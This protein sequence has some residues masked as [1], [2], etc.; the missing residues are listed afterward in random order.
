MCFSVRSLILISLVI[1]IRQRV[2]QTSEV[3]GDDLILIFVSLCYLPS[4]IEHGL[5]LVELLNARSTIREL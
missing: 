5:D 3:R 4:Y 2:E 1:S